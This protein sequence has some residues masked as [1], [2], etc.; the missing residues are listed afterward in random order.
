MIN[1]I[2]KSLYN[3]RS[4]DAVLTDYYV[5]RVI[6]GFIPQVFYW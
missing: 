3:P 5:R 4:I 6:T 1:K 2:F